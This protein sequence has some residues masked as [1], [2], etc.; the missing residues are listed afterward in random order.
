MV[1]YVILVKK[2]ISYA[3]MNE[4]LE[5][6]AETE[7]LMTLSNSCNT[8]S[9]GKLITCYVYL[10]HSLAT[11]FDVLSCQLPTSWGKK[12]LVISSL[13]SIHVARHSY[14]SVSELVCDFKH[15]VYVFSFYVKISGMDCERVRVKLYWEFKARQSNA[16]RKTSFT[17]LAYAMYWIDQQIGIKAHQ[18]YNALTKNS[19]FVL[20]QST[21][22]NI[23]NRQ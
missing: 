15:T 22:Q 10:S 5:C 18:T 3:L 6:T 12:R 21:T 2:N 4:T 17:R 1:K 9:N 11:L 16:K 7:M 23:N 13:H 8:R 19:I 20:Q 14:L